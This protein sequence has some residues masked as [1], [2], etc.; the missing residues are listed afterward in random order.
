MNAK[1][2]KSIFITVLYFTAML[3][4][5][6]VSITLADETLNETALIAVLKSDAGW[7]EKQAACRDLRRTGTAKSIPVLAALLLDEE[8]S[9][10]VR[11]ALE[12][13]PY[14]EVDQALRDALAE[15]TGMPKV[16]V[17]ISIGARRD[18]HAVA[19]LVPLLKGT[20]MDVAR[21]AAGA[22]GRIATPEA[23]KA[24][25]DFRSAVP[26][27]V[28]PA[29]AEGLLTAGQRFVQDGKGHLAA[30]VYQNL[31]ESSWP[32]H[33][34][35]GAFRGLVYAQPNRAQDRLIK[36]LG[37]NVPLFR[38][39]AA[40]IIAETTGADATKL[41]ADALPK[42]PTDGQAALLRG[43]ADR[44]DPSARPAV[45]KAIHSSDKQVKLAAVKALGVIGSAV[46][47]ATLA[48]LLVSDDD[49]IA[50]AAKAGLTTMQGEGVNSA[51]AAAVPNVAPASRVHLLELLAN[52]KAE[53]AVPMAVNSLKDTNVS[54]RIEALRTL[55]VLGGEE[56]APVV[57][58]AL[59]KAVDSSERAAA[60]KALGAICSRCGDNML[61]VVLDGMNGANLESRIVL[62]G[63]LGRIGGSKAI[64]P[65][66]AALNDSN[67]QIN[68]EAVRVLSNWSTLEAVPYLLE[69]AQS[70]KLSR[71]VLGLRGYIRLVRTEPSTKKKTRMLTKAMTL[72]KRPSEMKL[73][74]AALGTLPTEQSLNM[75]LLHLDDEE[76]RN[77]A[78]SAIVEV[79]AELGKKNKTRA[80]DALRSV[81]K[82]CKDEG[83][84]KSARK[85]LSIFK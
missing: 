43:L 30:P 39:M 37:G 56:Q 19:L 68:D 67:E 77:E 72:A 71:H 61:P 38:D 59:K 5:G 44:K 4:C 80:V 51:I 85:T 34:R 62:L 83:I 29:L 65:V 52:R 45:A 6:Q 75:L 76:M 84:R 23:I 49:D 58:A 1:I 63:A 18:V 69:L 3:A 8:L 28:R 64:K 20:E 16:G 82:K 73:V 74:M 42:L 35:M 11:Y 40:Q 36:A 70:D 17:I 21:A 31:L 14:P 46:D 57:V 47:V 50:H 41:Y 22:L 78:A 54:V 55:T 32:M 24:L 60:E 48:E 13:M 27:A 25:F 2:W 9:H 79:A 15:T 81:I 12:P 10:M 7:L 53:Q 66:L 33:V 26:R